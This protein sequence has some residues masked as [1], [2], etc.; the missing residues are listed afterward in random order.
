M[1]LTPGIYKI[2]NRSYLGGYSLL[3]VYLKQG[4]YRFRIDNGQEYDYEKSDN[5]QDYSIIKKLHILEVKNA[6]I[7]ITFDDEE[8]DGYQFNAR[9]L[10]VVS[11]IFRNYPPIATALGIRLLR[12]ANEGK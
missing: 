1:K 5:L 6:K 4:R 2:K 3:H 11:D 8:G 9:T 10:L 12:K 7:S